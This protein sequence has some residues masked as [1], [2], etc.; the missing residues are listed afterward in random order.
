MPRS[1]LY[2]IASAA[3]VAACNTTVTQPDVVK[4]TSVSGKAALQSQLAG[5]YG[6]FAEAYFGSGYSA[7]FIGAQAQEGQV[8][9][10]ALFTDEMH[11]TDYFTNHLQVD[12]RT[13]DRDN[14]TVDDA[15]RLIQRARLSADQTYLNFTTY[16]PT[17]TGRLTVLNLSGFSYVLLAETYCSNVPISTADASGNITY[18]APVG[19]DS[20]LHAAEAKFRQVLSLAAGD[21]AATGDATDIDYEVSR[22]NVGLARALLDEGKYAAAA[23]AAANVPDGYSDMIE[24]S[25]NSPGEEN[26]VYYYTN[27]EVRYA[28]TS[29]EGGNGLPY[30][31]GADPRIPVDTATATLTLGLDGVSNDSIQQ[32]YPLYGSSGPLATAVEARLIEAEAA[33][34]AGNG[35]LYIAKINDARSNW[36]LPALADPGGSAEVDTLFMERAYDLWLTGHRVGDLRRL[37][38]QY[39]R[40][41]TAVWPSGTY[42]KNNLQYGPQVAFPIPREEDNNP[43][44]SDAGCKGGTVP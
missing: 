44:Y 31:L 11:E 32:A 42:F 23:A 1:E 8:I 10:S 25:S 12:L 22:A 3:L 26:G 36:K 7:S 2:L 34:Q 30:P 24:R 35:G 29:S 5:A 41:R 17:N 19:T 21:S 15:Y 38:R 20:L 18:G 13:A 43:L 40:T 4:T 28:V 16:D 14:L 6:D 27:I 9:A 33:M 37:M 39:G